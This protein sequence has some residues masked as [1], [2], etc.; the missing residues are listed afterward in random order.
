M[1]LRSRRSESSESNACDSERQLVLALDADLGLVV[2][3]GRFLR[4]TGHGLDRPQR[5]LGQQVRERQRHEQRD[6]PGQ[7]H[8]VQDFL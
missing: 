6:E 1:S 5:G 4:G 7:R 8:Q 2:A 3:A